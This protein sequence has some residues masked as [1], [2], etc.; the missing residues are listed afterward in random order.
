MKIFGRKLKVTP[1][2]EV[3]M[4]RDTGWFPVK[5]HRQLSIHDIFD[6]YN[7]GRSNV[8]SPIWDRA[9]EDSIRYIGYG[10]HLSNKTKWF[11]YF[12]SKEQAVIFALR[13]NGVEGEED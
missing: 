6:M 4:K 8:N 7:W 9:I 12:P 13:F 2:F 3:K 5:V 11:W 1:E 10:G